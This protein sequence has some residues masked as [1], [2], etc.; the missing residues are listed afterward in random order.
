MA[1]FGEMDAR[2]RTIRNS[3][4]PLLDDFL[5]EAVWQPDPRNPLPREVIRM[6]ALRAYVE[7]FGA[8]PTDCCLVAEV[9]GRVI[10][11]AWSRCLHGFG[12][13]GEGIPELAVALLPPYRGRGIGTQLLRAM[14]DEL[15]G[16]D[17]AAV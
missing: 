15:R 9:G 5:Y 1:I 13:V 8:R 16:R 10:G 4:I 2:I 11:A 14:L 3:E 6:P 12:W 7:A 17:F